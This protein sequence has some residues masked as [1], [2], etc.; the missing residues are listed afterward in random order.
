M[1][2][3]ISDIISKSIV[4]IMIVF[5]LLFNNS[6]NY[7]KYVCLILL[8]INVIS[9][10]KVR[11]NWLF[12]V[13]LCFIFYANIS[14][15]MANYFNIVNDFFTSFSEDNVSIIG[16]NIL[17]LFN[18]GIFIALPKRIEK[19]RSEL[20]TVIDNIS[21]SS[22]VVSGIIIALMFILIFFFSRPTV[23]GQRGASSTIYE[24]AIILFIVGYF[25]ANKIQKNILHVIL[26]MYVLQDLMFGNRVTALQL[27]ILLFLILFSKKLTINKAVLLGIFGIIIFTGIG[28]F[29]G[30][31]TLS[32]STVNQV[33]N[34]LLR[35][36]FINDTSYSAYY[37]SLTFIKV[38]K[39]LSFDRRLIYF[40]PFFLS[41][42]FGG[43]IPNSSL[44]VITHKYFLHYYGGI[45]PYFFNF[46]FGVAG[47]LISIFILYLFFKMLNNYTINNNIFF[48]AIAI[49]I[50][51]TV[52]R[53]YLYSPLI[54]FRGSIFI[55]IIVYIVKRL[56]KYKVSI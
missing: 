1:K 56:S 27:I 42:I 39:I 21:K 2:R 16:I 34:N 40:I 36:G 33:F 17:F 10:Y 45:F 25:F 9:I 55:V 51:C 43:N 6:L 3:K 28:Q 30:N 12:V 20:I 44:P 23:S 22:T 41:I 24:Y 49:Y 37:T 7:S 50:T 19:N 38:G 46:Y 31:F 8:I 35:T 53:W 26:I 32:L 14:I 52:P 48:Q 29:R 15:V 13:I 54:L 4:F 18:A 47:V 5:V 11:N